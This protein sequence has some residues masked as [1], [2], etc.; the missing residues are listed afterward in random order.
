MATL[1]FVHF[2]KKL[3]VYLC[4]NI[5]RTM[6][7]FPEH[8]IVLV[9][10]SRYSKGSL[11]LNLL[12]IHPEKLNWE[13]SR[14][15]IQR[16]Q[17]F[18]AGWWQKTFD[19]LLMIYPIHQMFPGDS[20]L[21]IESDTIIFPSFPFNEL[22][23][24]GLI[25]YPMFSPFQAVASVVFSPSVEK[26]RILEIEI[27]RE[28]S[29]SPTTSDMDALGAIVPRLSD[30]FYELQEFQK[31]AGGEDTCDLEL[32]C[33]DGLSHGEWVCGQDPKAH[34]GIGMRRRRTPNSEN[35]IFPKYGY[36][37]NQMFL[38]FDNSKVNLNNLH[39]HSKENYF[40][41][42]GENRRLN[43]TLAKVNKNKSGFLHFFSIPA[44][45]YCLRSNIAI[46]SSSGFSKAAWKRLMGR[47]FQ[48]QK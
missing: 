9:T 43:L 14:V 1:L 7:L 26:S 25:A 12:I 3:P 46:W 38:H 28:L 18:W 48:R 6:E 30:D 22:E 5:E 19:R 4:K 15:Q 17:R 47:A 32:G 29:E 23:K 8:K 33:F 36:E 45:F 21:H 40:F 20:I 34:W 10:N 13:R 2:G 16:D 27:L 24:K 31:S 44:F 39:V 42:L 37:S 35:A 41:C 11:P